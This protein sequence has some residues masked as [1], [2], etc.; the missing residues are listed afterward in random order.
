MAESLR[1]KTQLRRQMET[2]HLVT[3]TAQLT[4]RY[5]GSVSSRDI[6]KRSQAKNR[7]VEKNS[8]ES[9]QNQI[10]VL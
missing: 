3:S 2:T 1:E 9:T 7:P 10:L 8:S 4:P 5:V 6:P